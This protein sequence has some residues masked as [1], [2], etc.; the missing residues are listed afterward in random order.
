MLG[1][2]CLLTIVV[3]KNRRDAMLRVSCQNWVITTNLV[4]SWCLH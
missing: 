1:E 4:C 2:E 3:R